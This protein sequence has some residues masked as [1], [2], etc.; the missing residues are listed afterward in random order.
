MIYVFIIN[1][2][3]SLLKKYNSLK[4]TFGIIDLSSSLK[5]SVKLSYIDGVHYSPDANKKI[6]IRIYNIIFNEIN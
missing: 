6:A 1:E 4:D 5:N 2:S 3:G